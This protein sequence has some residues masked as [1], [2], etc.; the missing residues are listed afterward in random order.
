MPKLMLKYKLIPS[1]DYYLYEAK[2]ED[3]GI[4]YKS[5][6]KEV[7]VH[8]RYLVIRIVVPQGIEGKVVD[9]MKDIKIINV[10][11]I[12]D[13]YGNRLRNSD[14]NDYWYERGRRIWKQNSA[15]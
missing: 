6:E 13:F 8:D 12:D 11:N 4:I 15:V 3:G 10:H 9:F 5:P 2:N 7:S 1:E 14:W